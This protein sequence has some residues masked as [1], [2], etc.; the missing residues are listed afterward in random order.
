VSR[1]IGSLFA[2]WFAL[3]LPTGVPHS[4]Q[5]FVSAYFKAFLAL[6]VAASG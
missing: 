4:P 1:E 6:F 5:P 2:N 3:A